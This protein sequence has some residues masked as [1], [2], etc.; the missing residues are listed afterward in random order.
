MNTILNALHSYNRYLILA[1]IAFGLLI[2][3]IYNKFQ[4]EQHARLSG[5]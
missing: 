3:T 2:L 1:A 4:K 5:D